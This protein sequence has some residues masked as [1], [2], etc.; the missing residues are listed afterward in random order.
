MISHR[1]TTASHSAEINYSHAPRSPIPS[2]KLLYGNG[3]NGHNPMHQSPCN[4][5]LLGGMDK[6]RRGAYH[7][8][9]R[10]LWYRIFFSTPA[11][12]GAT[13]LIFLYF[14]WRYAIIPTVHSIYDW[15]VYLS[16]GSKPTPYDSKSAFLSVA[17]DPKIRKEILKPVKALKENEKLLRNSIEALRKPDVKTGQKRMEAIKRIVPQW[18][19]RNKVD[20]KKSKT[21]DERD[22]MKVEKTQNNNEKPKE[23]NAK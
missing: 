3:S 4:S 8:R 18:F 14:S 5:F 16:S 22:D 9:Q 10:S 23:K 15:G 7:P 11:R 1:R 19:D 20:T 2:R 21:I 17:D 6:R 12:A 13:T